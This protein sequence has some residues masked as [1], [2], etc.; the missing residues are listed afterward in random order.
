MMLYRT[1]DMVR[2]TKSPDFDP[3]HSAF[4]MPTTEGP[5]RFGQDKN[6]QRLVLDELGSL[7][8]SDWTRDMLMY[9]VNQRC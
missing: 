9:V 4:F 2:I 5:C 3:D 7:K 8:M 1:G 6:L